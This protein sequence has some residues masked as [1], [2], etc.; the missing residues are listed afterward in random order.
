[1]DVE[2]EVWARSIGIDRIESLME[3]G[4]DQASPSA[5]IDVCIIKALLHPFRRFR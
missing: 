4:G 2:D 5:T 3:K 1:M